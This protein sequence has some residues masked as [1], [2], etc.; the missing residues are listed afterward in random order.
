MFQ[1]SRESRTNPI[2]VLP[3]HCREPTNFSSLSPMSTRHWNIKF[4]RVLFSFIRKR[5]CYSR[6]LSFAQKIKVRPA[7]SACDWA[8]LRPCTRSADT[9]SK[10]TADFCTRS[11]SLQNNSTVVQIL[12]CLQCTW[13]VNAVLE[14]VVIVVGAFHQIEPAEGFVWKLAYFITEIRKSRKFQV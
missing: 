9:N 12:H 8:R 5:I 2:S 1:P 11:P 6:N 3:I 13:I 10:S 7:E 4:L 14:I